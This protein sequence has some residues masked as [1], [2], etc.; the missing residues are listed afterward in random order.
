M[1]L[2]RITSEQLTTNYQ[3]SA[4]C[5]CER[6][7]GTLINVEIDILQAHELDSSFHARCS[8]CHIDCDL[9]QVPGDFHHVG[10]SG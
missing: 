2:T 5:Q 8:C 7:K 3:C 4:G 9:R 6:G 1:Q 10:V